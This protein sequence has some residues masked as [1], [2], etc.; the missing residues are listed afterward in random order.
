MEEKNELTKV[1]ER[2]F[3]KTFGRNNIDLLEKLLSPE[4]LERIDLTTLNTM[5][6]T[7]VDRD[8]DEHRPGRNK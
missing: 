6:E 4:D 3:R 7:Y 8:F 2:Y 1:H 5:E